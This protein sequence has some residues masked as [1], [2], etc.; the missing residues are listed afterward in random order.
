MITCNPNKTFFHMVGLGLHKYENKESSKE[1][2]KNIESLSSQKEAEQSESK[3]ADLDRFLPWL[4]SV[5]AFSFSTRS[6]LAL[7]A[8]ASDL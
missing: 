3:E 8:L 6:S 2:N 1:K 5:S 4:Y 7:S